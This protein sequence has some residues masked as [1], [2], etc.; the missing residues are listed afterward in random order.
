MLLLDQ[1]LMSPPSHHFGNLAGL[2][3]TPF[4][5]ACEVGVK[6]LTGRSEQIA[7]LLEDLAAA[8]ASANGDYL[9]VAA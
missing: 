4:R 3:F 2:Q 1:L 9:R 7:I 6:I 8:L 5:L